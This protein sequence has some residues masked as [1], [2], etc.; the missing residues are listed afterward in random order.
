MGESALAQI[1]LPETLGTGRRLS[2]PFAVTFGAIGGLIGAL[3][4]AHI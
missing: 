2:V 1:F 3:L 4:G